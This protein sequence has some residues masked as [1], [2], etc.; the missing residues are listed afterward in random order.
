M[1][2]RDLGQPLA[3]HGVPQRRQVRPH[4]GARQVLSQLPLVGRQREEEALRRTPLRRVAAALAGGVE[5]VDALVGLRAGLA[6]AAVRVR[7]AVRADAGDVGLE[8]EPPAVPA[9]RR[10]AL[11]RDQL[12]AGVETPDEVCDEARVPRRRERSDVDVRLDPRPP[13]GLDDLVVEARRHRGRRRAQLL[14]LGGD[15]A[16]VVVAAGDEEGF[17]AGEAAVAL[18]DVRGQVGPREVTDVKVAVRGRRRGGDQYSFHRR[19]PVSRAG[20]RSSASSCSSAI[21]CNSGI[22][23]VRGGVPGLAR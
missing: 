16:L 9:P 12:A 3:E 7:A 2:D 22:A 6:G 1:G 20:S 13:Q 10:V 23:A 19:P 5:E 14:G 15:I 8:E 18:V 11:P 17:P 21:A 4:A